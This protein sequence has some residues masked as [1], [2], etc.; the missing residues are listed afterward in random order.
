MSHNVIIGADTNNG[1]LVRL[2]DPGAVARSQG[3]MASLAATVAPATIEAKVYAEVARQ[4]KSKL[5][6]QGI[7][8]DVQVVEPTAFK[9]TGGSHIATDIGFAIGGAG[10]LAVLWY[11]FSGKK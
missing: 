8:V 3:A 9:S 2:R 10:V 1:I 6:A 7:D 5:A 11:L 4:L